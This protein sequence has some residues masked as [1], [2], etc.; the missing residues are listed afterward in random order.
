[1]AGHPS[2][3][4]A[5]AS[6][7]GGLTSAQARRLAEEHGPNDLP[8]RGPTPAWR[9]LLAQIV[10]P[11]VLLLL[12]SSAVA[13]SLGHWV[14]ASAIFTIVSI[15]AVVGF[16]QEYR[17][18]RAVLALRE[19]TARR[20]RVLRDGRPQMI[21]ATEV[22][23]GD[24]LVLEAGDIVAADA[25][26]CAASRLTAEEAALTGESMPVEKRVEAA[27]ADAPLAERHDMVFLGTSIAT[28]TGAAI[29]TAIGPRTEM[30]HIAGMLESAGTTVTPMQRRLA[31]LGRILVVVCVVMVVLVAAI[32]AARGL[33]LLELLMTSVSLAVAAVPEGLPAVV[34]V[35]LAVGVRRMARHGVLVRRLSA[36]ETLGSATV[37]CT[38]KTGTLT[39]GVMT[40]RALLG[41]RHEVLRA[42]AACC[43]A[44][45]HGAPGAGDPTE[46]AVLRAAAELG[47]ER[48][49]IETTEPRL[50][51]EPFDPQRRM[52]S[53]LREGERLYVKGAA[54]EVLSR[55]HDAAEN[56][57]DE[58]E[59]MAGNGLRVLA[60]AT[61][62]GEEERDLHFVGLVGLADAP[63]PEAIHAIAQARRAGVRVVMITGD[64]PRTARAIARDVGL[65]RDDAEAAE[66][67]HARATAADKTEIV[68]K[69]RARGEIVAMTGDGVNDAPSIREADIGVAMGKTATE[70]TR[71]ASD[72]VLTGDDLSG[73]VDAI[74]QGRIVYTNVRKTIVYLLGGN[75]AELVL[76]L[77]AA[78]I[79]L[80][81]PLLPLHLLWIN[82]VG[83]PLPG[84]T[85]AIDPPASDVLDAPPRPPKESIV[86]P[87]DWM[88]IGA[89]AVL[90]AMVALVVFAWALQRADLDHA[91]T[92]AF[93][94]LVFGVILRAL[95]ARDARRLVLE[96]KPLENLPLL[97]VVL[98]SLAATA[99]L[100]A[101]PFTREI[102]QLQS[103]SLGELAIAGAGGLVPVT[104]IELSKLW[105][106]R[107]EAAPA[108]APP[109]KVS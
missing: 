37:I 46:L 86:R 88:E 35:A 20:A 3:H 48:D 104:S 36:V 81:L 91:R 101:L 93:I 17:A 24:V 102:F 105:L 27:A 29:V 1:M 31:E 72:M 12:G 33:G 98:A 34:T 108:T 97:L 7:A 75:A 65:A 67:V 4:P 70:V 39:T 71:E 44:D 76:M 92:L 25:R 2:S 66:L 58:A 42:A 59:A 19:L 23:P 30:G 22:V 69:L 47:I 94:T 55:C 103:L 64:H 96:A 9:V 63:R 60:V 6:A 11:L 26:L 14:D 106:R 43:D 90:Q 85:L 95:A 82:L 61:G 10:S 41:D 38:D 62:H 68:R 5:G 83:E 49:D 50:R 107:R 28:G 21:T 53:V 13:A 84:L 57:C 15:N 32:G 16:V 99:A 80:P 73:I 40:V 45:L 74:R 87:R 56:A 109:A 79:G 77:V 54:E 100:T 78:A 52:M 51:T 89:M 8:H 18:E